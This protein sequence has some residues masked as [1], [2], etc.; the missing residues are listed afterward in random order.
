MAE[1]CNSLMELGRHI[2]QPSEPLAERWTRGWEKLLLEL[3]LLES[4]L[5][6]R[7]SDASH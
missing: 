1:H 5:L 2:M 3:A 4:E 7:R 6:A